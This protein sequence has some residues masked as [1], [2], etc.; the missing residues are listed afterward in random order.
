MTVN[1]DKFFLWPI[2]ETHPWR[3][4]ILLF[5]SLLGA[6]K[7]LEDIFKA[8]GYYDPSIKFIYYLLAATFTG[9]AV[10]LARS[11]A[12]IIRGE[13]N[14]CPSCRSAVDLSAD[15][16]KYCGAEVKAVGV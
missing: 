2:L 12:R 10:S 1:K 5:F 11:Q 3:A 15:N 6:L 7:I 16:C 14:R 9:N 8:L 13:A 4:V